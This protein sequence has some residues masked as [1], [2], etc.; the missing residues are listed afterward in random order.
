M[1][2]KSVQI[3][4][5]HRKKPRMRVLKL[6]VPTYIGNVP[7]EGSDQVDV[8]QLGESDLPLVIDESKSPAPD[9]GDRHFGKADARDPV[10]RLHRDF[11]EPNVPVLVCEADGVR[12]VLGTHRYNDYSKPDI[13]IERRPNGW[14]IFLHPLGGSDPSGYVYFLDDGCSFL[15]KE[16]G[17][18]PT[19]VIEVL[20]AD[21]GV[22][23]LDRVSSISRQGIPDSGSRGASEALTNSGVGDRNDKRCARCFEGLPYS[24]E[25]YGELCPDCA[26]ATDGDWVCRLCGNRGSFEI[27]GGSGA[28]DPVCCGWPCKHINSESP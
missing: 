11:S 16:H 1:L 20:E 18:G 14:A 8:P 4:T 22:P 5:S 7:A 19:D 27:M 6:M 23:E 26:D 17:L 13:Q 15:V 9:I 10:M 24:S 2:P 12:V 21:E 3:A 28:H 25:S